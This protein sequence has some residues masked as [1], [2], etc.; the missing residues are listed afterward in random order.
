MCLFEVSR[1]YSSNCLTA[2]L[3]QL[4]LLLGLYSKEELAGNIWIRLVFL[5]IFI[6]TIHFLVNLFFS[7]FYYFLLWLF[8]QLFQ[9][10][11]LSLIFLLSFSALLS[12]LLYS[13]HFLCSISMYPVCP[14]I[15]SAGVVPYS[16]P[17]SV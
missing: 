5:I 3:F 13:S 6:F 16:V 17:S 15:L 11:L 9:L 4:N 10:S 14:L 12:I 7:L 2:N 1:K 8:H